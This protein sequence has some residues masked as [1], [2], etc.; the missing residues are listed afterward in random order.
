MKIQPILIYL[1]YFYCSNLIWA[2][3]PSFREIG[4]DFFAETDIY[5]LLEDKA[6]NIWM[7]RQAMKKCKT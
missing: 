3:Q 5:S 7:T 1:L 4:A 6:Q 2:Q